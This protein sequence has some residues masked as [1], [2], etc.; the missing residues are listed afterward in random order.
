MNTQDQQSNF[1][2]AAAFIHDCHTQNKSEEDAKITYLFTNG[3]AALMRCSPAAVFAS[4]INDAITN[5][6]E[7]AL[8]TNG[9]IA[10]DIACIIICLL[11]QGSRS[12]LRGNNL[13]TWLLSPEHI[14]HLISIIEMHP[15]L[16][17]ES[18]FKEYG[19]VKI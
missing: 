6:Y 16:T 12:Q 9:K 3:N 2:N 19:L 5:A 11:Y 18:G 14:E 4:N 15:R 7:Q 1:P 13:K 17:P 10:A 8:D